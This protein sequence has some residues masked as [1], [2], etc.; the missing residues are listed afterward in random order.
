[1]EI[2]REPPASTWA[3]E[4]LWTGLLADGGGKIRT[5]RFHGPAIR[6]FTIFP[7]TYRMHSDYGICGL[8]CLSVEERWLH[9]VVGTSVARRIRQRTR[10]LAL[11]QRYDRLIHIDL[12]DAF[13]LWPEKVRPRLTRV[14]VGVLDIPMLARKVIQAI[15]NREN[16]WT[17]SQ[18]IHQW[19]HSH[20]REGRGEWARN[21]S[22]ASDWDI[23]KNRDGHFHFEDTLPRLAALFVNCSPFQWVDT[24]WSTEKTFYRSLR[25]RRRAA[26]FVTDS[27]TF[28]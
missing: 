28:S 16:C 12:A 23:N 19:G 8:E 14:F 7:G 2:R 5:E 17:R 25:L 27:W 20:E 22:R 3:S 26:Q 15:K 6:K 21:V 10:R 24:I 1:M 18:R 11:E 13:P 4:R 9:C